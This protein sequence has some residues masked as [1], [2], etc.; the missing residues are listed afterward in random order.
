M[1]ICWKMCWTLWSHRNPC[2]TKQQPDKRHACVIMIIHENMYIATVWNYI[3]DVLFL[4]EYSCIQLYNTMIQ[5]TAVCKRYK[6][7]ICYIIL[8]LYMAMSNNIIITLS[9]LY[10]ML[11]ERSR[12]VTSCTLPPVD[13]CTYT[14]IVAKWLWINAIC[15]WLGQYCM[16]IEHILYSCIIYS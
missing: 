8:R 15:N 6:V 11:I 16:A 14:Y 5:A 1:T 10:T 13:M 4:W 2:Q 9:N 7:R 3:I 12:H